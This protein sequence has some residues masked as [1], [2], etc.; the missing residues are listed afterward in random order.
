M[1]TMIVEKV[2]REPAEFFGLSTDQKPTNAVNADIFYEMD[3][4]KMYLYNEAGKTW[5]EQ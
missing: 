2:T 5:I 1:I 4:A 3:T